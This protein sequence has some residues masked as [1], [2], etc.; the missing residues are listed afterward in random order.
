MNILN[1]IIISLLSFKYINSYDN[2]NY[3]KKNKIKQKYVWRTN[4]T[5]CYKNR[6]EKHIDNNLIK[7]Q[8]ELNFNIWNEFFPYE[9]TK[10]TFKTDITNITNVTYKTNKTNKTGICN[11]KF[12]IENN[13]HFD[14]NNSICKFSPNTLAHASYPYVNTNMSFIHIKNDYIKAINNKPY[15][16][17]KLTML[18]MHEIGHSLGIEH[19]QNDTN[20]IMYSIINSTNILYR[21][22]SVPYMEKLI[23]TKDILALQEI[24]SNKLIKVDND[25]IY[26]TKNGKYIYVGPNIECFTWIVLIQNWIFTC[27]I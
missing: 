15:Y 10:R 13:I 4:I 3:Y 9:I 20:N 6:Y 17:Y 22:H 16:I 19:I 27:N 21:F 12:S 25:W 18:F 7:K 14:R 11:I 26:N 2:N 23:S 5:W 24:Y 1:I 8:V